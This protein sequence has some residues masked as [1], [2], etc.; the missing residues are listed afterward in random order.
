MQA[1]ATSHQVR[2]CT[3]SNFL[4]NDV[5]RIHLSHLLC[6]AAA[7]RQGGSI[8]NIGHAFQKPTSPLTQSVLRSTFFEFFATIKVRQYPSL[9]PQA[10]FCSARKASV[11]FASLL[12]C[13][14][15]CSSCA[16]ASLFTITCPVLLLAAAARLPC[17][18]NAVN[19]QIFVRADPVSKYILLTLV[20]F[21]I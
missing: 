13:L 17:P 4:S 7:A 11:L 12:V 9:F 3:P 20:F 14:L 6:G 19:G 2:S 10:F 15:W 16:L 18:R 1:R 5:V 21:H 8:P